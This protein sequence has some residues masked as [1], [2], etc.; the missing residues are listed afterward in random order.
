MSPESG[1]QRV[2]TL[3]SR[4]QVT[5]AG[6]EFGMPALEDDLCDAPAGQLVQ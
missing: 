3:K 5:V 6:I 4:D 1:G 2:P